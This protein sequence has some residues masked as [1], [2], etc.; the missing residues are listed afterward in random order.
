MRLRSKIII[1]II[2]VFIIFASW[3]V[4]YIK[5]GDF[6]RYI[7]SHHSNI[8]PPVQYFFAMMLNLSGRKESALRWFLK[9]HEQYPKNSYAPI[10]WSE[11]IEILDQKSERARMTEE[12]EKFL[13]E[14]PDHPKSEIVRKKQY[15]LKYGY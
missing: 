2:I 1:L 8:I 5:K 12:I 3:T 4:N 14:Y 13:Q 9:V 10:A 11:A 6:E 15:L 7:D